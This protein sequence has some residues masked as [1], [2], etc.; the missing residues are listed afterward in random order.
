VNNLPV[1]QALYLLGVSHVDQVD[2]VTVK[3]SYAAISE[4]MARFSF[5]DYGRGQF[6][7]EINSLLSSAAR[8]SAL[9]SSGAATLGNLAAKV[10]PAFESPAR[11]ATRKYDMESGKFFRASELK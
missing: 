8:L 6:P 1:D 10:G 11:Y 5:R 2:V 9:A 7:S 3:R 4:C